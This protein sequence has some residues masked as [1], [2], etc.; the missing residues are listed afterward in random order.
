[1]FAFKGAYKSLKV[2][3]IGKKSYSVMKVTLNLELM[4]VGFGGKMEK[5]TKVFAVLERPNL[6]KY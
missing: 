6:Q 3:Q 4:A 2:L 1:M 5:T